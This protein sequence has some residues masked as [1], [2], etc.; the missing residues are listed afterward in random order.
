MNDVGIKIFASLPDAIDWEK[1]V[2]YNKFLRESKSRD[3]SDMLIEVRDL[4]R[5][6][7]CKN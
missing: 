4:L 3:F 2:P 5:E 6:D 1:L 7:K